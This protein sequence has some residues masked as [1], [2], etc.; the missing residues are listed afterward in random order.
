[1]APW[2]HSCHQNGSSILQPLL[3]M[4]IAAM[5]KFIV[6]VF[7][8]FCCLSFFSFGTAAMDY[9]LVYPSRAI[10]GE[11]EFIAY[12]DLLEAAIL[13]VSVV[14]FF[15][16]TILNGILLW[17]RPPGVSTG[18]LVT[19][20][21][22]LI[23]VWLSSIFIQIPMNLQLNDGKNMELIQQVIDTNW[24]RVVF[25]TTEAVLCFVMLCQV[26]MRSTEVK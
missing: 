26:V 16:I 9:F 4:T 13:P 1:M 14:P 18:L 7:S 11:H 25:E 20:L 2:G 23:I 21:V 5:K 17:R 12:H 19:T 24:G 22:C 10:V 6:I 15:L 3:K 8:L